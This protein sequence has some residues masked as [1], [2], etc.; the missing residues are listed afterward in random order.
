MTQTD[1]GSSHADIGQQLN[2]SS[3]PDEP[4]NAAYEIQPWT[5]L[6]RKYLAYLAKSAYREALTQG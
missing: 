6:L 2:G 1:N 4:P 3:I 5:R